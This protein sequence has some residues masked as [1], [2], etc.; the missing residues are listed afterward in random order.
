MHFS[1]RLFSIGQLLILLFLPLDTPD[2]N[3]L[4]A[5]LW[6][7]FPKECMINDA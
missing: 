5:K 1:G 6:F 3:D 4:I 7:L 2:P